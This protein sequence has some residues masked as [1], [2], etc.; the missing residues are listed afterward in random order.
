ML[1]D[2]RYVGGLIAAGVTYATASMDSSW[3]WRL[4]TALQG[5]FTLLILILLPFIPESPRWLAFVSR[6]EESRQALAYIYTNGNIDDPV[7]HCEFLNISQSLALSRET[8]GTK[9]I[10]RDMV[11]VPS[12]RKRALLMLS[13]A[14]FSMLS[15]NNIISYYLGSML[16]EAGITDTTIQLQVVSRE[17]RIRS[18]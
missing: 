17:L 15:G 7:V 12:D 6:E 13:V 8:S 16:D 2:C 9:K 10:M 5:V 11:K 1:T 4:P 3:A 14:L 18:M